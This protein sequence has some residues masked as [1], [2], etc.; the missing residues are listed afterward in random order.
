[1][2]VVMHL[3]PE[4]EQIPVFWS[5]IWGKKYFWIADPPRLPNLKH[6]DIVSRKFQELQSAI[7]MVIIS[8]EFPT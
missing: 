5:V 3:P 7:F 2:D 1:L 4:A 8:E 6:V